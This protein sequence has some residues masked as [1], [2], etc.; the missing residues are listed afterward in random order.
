MCRNSDTTVIDYRQIYEDYEIAEDE[1]AHKAIVISPLDLE[2]EE[3]KDRSRDE[4]LFIDNTQ[5]CAVK[6]LVT[7]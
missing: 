4:L 3:V 5:G 6:D 1:I 7:K 2:P